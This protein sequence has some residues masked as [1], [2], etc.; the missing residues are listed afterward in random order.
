[1]PSERLSDRA[2]K[3]IRKY[4][5]KKAQR[6]E[7]R[8]QQ[9][10]RKLH[11]RATK[12]RSV[13][14]SEGIDEDAVLIEEGVLSH[15]PSEPQLGKPENERIRTRDTLATVVE[16]Y[17]KEARVSCNGHVFRAHFA[18]SIFQNGDTRST[19]TV[20]DQVILAFQAPK[21]ARVEE[22]LPRRSALTRAVGDASR[23]GDSQRDHVLAANIDQVIVVSSVAEPP[24]RPRLIDRYLVAAFRDNLPVVLCINKVDLG[25][26]VETQAYLSGYE[27]LGFAVLLTSVTSGKGIAALRDVV[28]GQTTLFTG[29][30]GVGKSSMLNA[31]EPGLA[32]RV[33][34]VTHAKAGQGKGTHTTSSA[35]LLPLSAPDTFV[36]DSPGIRTLGIGGLAPQELADHFPDIAQ[37][38]SSCRFRDCLHDGEQGCSLSDAAAL[39]G[40]QNA[41]WESYRAL[42]HE[43]H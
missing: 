39:S 32:L 10:Q 7:R 37:L 36:V 11:H 24:F 23:R 27:A 1:M 3:R 8:E 35:R 22:V 28:E 12:P 18:P 43:L 19:V 40:F 15:P 38:A 13:R 5:E 16:I 33:G 42:L 41:R 31:L 30:S 14:T 34:S 29:H 6:L 26:S 20:G 25:L 2:F 21:C 17:A 9:K 4:F